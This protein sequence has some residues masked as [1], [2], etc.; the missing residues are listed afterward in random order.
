MLVFTIPETPPEKNALKTYS[1]ENSSWPQDSNRRLFS[2]SNRNCKAKRKL[3]LC[4]LKQCPV[5]RGESPLSS[6]PAKASAPAQS[7][8]PAP[9]L[10]FPQERLGT[11]PQPCHPRSGA[12]GVRTFAASSPSC[13]FNLATGER[14]PNSSFLRRDDSSPHAD[15]EVHPCAPG[16]PQLMLRTKSSPAFQRKKNQ[17]CHENSKAF[18]VSLTA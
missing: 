8:T 18:V 13:P 17:K 5:Q 10:C 6:S 2:N 4:I 3:N 15:Q 14:S 7:P 11:P 9:L 1:Y 12:A 16:W